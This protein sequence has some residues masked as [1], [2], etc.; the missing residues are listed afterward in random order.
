MQYC[1]EKNLDNAFRN[2]KIIFIATT[3]RFST[4]KAK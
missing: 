2:C 1:V 4:M 3:G